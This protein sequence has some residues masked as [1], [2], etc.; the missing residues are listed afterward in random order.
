[1]SPS[2]HPALH[3]S[4]TR[5]L[6]VRRVAL[7][8]VACLVLAATTPPAAADESAPHGAWPLRPDPE[9]TT[10]FDPP[11][12]PWGAGHRGVDLRGVPGQPVRSALPGRVSFVGR[13]AGR[14]I[15]VVDHGD[16]RTTY[17]P[18]QATVPLGESVPAGAPLGRLE[19]IGSHCAPA[20]CLHWGWLRGD[21]YLDPLLLVGGGPIRLLPLDASRSADQPVRWSAPTSPYA[22]WR[23]AS[24]TGWPHQA[25]GCACW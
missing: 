16:T 13:L 9:V 23:P 22:A 15:V 6:R 17:E 20:A 5:H 8:A 18:V 2:A 11:E 19:A 12:S 24:V 21:V 14:G 25:R 7:T 4:R 3:P 1:M 10:R